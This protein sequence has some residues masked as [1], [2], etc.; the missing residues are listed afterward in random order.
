MRP[1]RTLPTKA[2]RYI[3]I[4]QSKTA[5]EISNNNGQLL[6]SDNHNDQNRVTVEKMHEE[7]REQMSETS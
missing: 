3:G 6:K 1:A 4:T 5:A 7:Q 2:V